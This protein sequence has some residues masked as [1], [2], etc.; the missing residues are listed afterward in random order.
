MHIRTILL[1]SFKLRMV[2]DVPVGMFL[3]GGVDSST[4]TSMLQKASNKQLKTFTI[5]FD[6]PEYNEAE[7]AKAVAKHIGTDHTELYCS[8]QDFEKIVPNIPEILDEP[9]GDSSIIPTH[10]VAKLYL[11]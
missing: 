8:T 9:M 4:V 6:N 7:H 2:A 1:D 5:G 3:S 10:L 11:F